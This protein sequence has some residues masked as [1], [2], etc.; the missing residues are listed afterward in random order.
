MTETLSQITSDEL[1]AAHNTYNFNLNISGQLVLDAQDTK[2]VQ[3][4]IDE[5]VQ[6]TVDGTTQTDQE[7]VTSDELVA[8]HNTYNFNLNISGQLVLDAQ[9]T[10]NI[11]EN[12]DEIVQTS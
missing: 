1:V 11:H 10:E 12:T 4:N 5:I 8:A 7:A 6:D 9:A 3:E 2:H